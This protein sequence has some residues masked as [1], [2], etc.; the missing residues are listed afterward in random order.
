RAARRIA[1][2]NAARRARE[3]ER[4]AIFWGLVEENGLQLEQ[5]TTRV[6]RDL[7]TQAKWIQQ[8]LDQKDE[9]ARAETTTGPAPE[10]SLADNSPSLLHAGH[11][12]SGSRGAGAA[13]APAL[14][15]RSGVS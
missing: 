10:G 8:C 3:A 13:R 1:Q 12:P 2:M 15:A 4:V 6:R 7:V 5:L 11:A 14:A 9:R